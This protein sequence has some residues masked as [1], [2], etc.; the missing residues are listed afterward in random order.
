LRRGT[1]AASSAWRSIV[2][3]GVARIEIETRRGEESGADVAREEGVTATAV[4]GFGQ[5]KWRR[6]TYGAA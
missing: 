1:E 3:N 6:R 5:F 2:E 4:G